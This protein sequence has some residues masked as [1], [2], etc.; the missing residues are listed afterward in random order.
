MTKTF[1]AYEPDQL[2]LL[3]PS[4]REWLPEDHL[5]YFVSEVVDVLDLS[6]VYAAYTEARGQPPYHPRLM[7]K[8]I[9]YGY[10]T[11]VR[12]LRKLARACLEDV[13]FRVL[14]AGSVPD[15]RT[16]AAFRKRHLRVLSE[17]FT[18]V[19][20]LCKEAGLVRLGHVAVNGTKVRAHASKHKAMSYGRMR[21]GRG[22]SQGR[23]AGRG[24]AGAGGA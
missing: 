1:R 15:F 14:C 7:T 23:G 13:P 19:L 20:L 21:E 10:A 16:I 4:L 18:E 17:L 12:S 8:L 11:G 24:G 3:P 9:L 5:V 2:P 22:A 6:E